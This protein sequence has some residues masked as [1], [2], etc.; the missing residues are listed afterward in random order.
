MATSSVYL[1]LVLPGLGEY[2]DT[3][4]I[5]VNEN[6]E[7]IDDWAAS[8]GQEVVD[9]RGSAVSLSAFLTVA[10]NADGSLKPTASEAEASSSQ[11]YGY[12]NPD[13]T[14]FSLNDRITAGDWEVFGGREGQASLRAAAALRAS[15]PTQIL[16]GSKD[17]NGYPAWMGFTANKVQVDGDSQLLLF[18]ID[19][20]LSRMRTLQE[21]TLSGG[22][23]TK[24]PYAS[25]EPDGV[26]TVDG[27]LSPGSG[28]GTI[29]TTID[30]YAAYFNDATKDFTTEDVQPG[31]I[32][33]LI[34]STSI[35]TYIVKTVAPGAIVSRLEIVGLFPTSGISGINYIISDPLAVSLGFDTAEVPATGKIYLGEADYDGV[36]VT[37]VRPRHFKDVFVGEWRA[38]DVT[39]TATFEEI[40]LHKLGSD[41]LD[42]SIQ[43]SQAN[44]GS[45][46]VE[47]LDLATFTSNLGVSLNNTLGVS[48]TN[49]LNFTPGTFNPGTT[50]ASYIPGSLT[51][52]ITGALTGSISAALT[53][54]IEMDRA[55]R[56]KWDKNRIHV[57]NVV[58][59]VFYTDYDG[60]AQ[61]TG[62]IRV[63]VRKRG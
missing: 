14:D 51:G 18:M 24:Y 47:E 31:D 10:H 36:A 19:G 26:I 3:W 16:S 9:A 25:F 17:G 33:E 42:F 59:N 54:D 34:D 13:T 48:I 49:G 55:V 45:A 50:D 46:P 56:V 22:A 58:G 30:G 32:L 39:S 21:I 20:Y 28:N 38:V 40:F 52:S 44:D 61:Q 60:T 8:F 7:K 63:V 35:G 2:R 37:A 23:G 4:H 53:G 5:P 11:V 27:D 62:F 15:L 41:Q 29:S 6:M 57:K 1:S 43:V 12:L